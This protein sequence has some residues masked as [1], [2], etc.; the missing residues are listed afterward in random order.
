GEVAVPVPPASDF[1][2]VS[3]VTV[4]RP[5]TYSRGEKKIILIDCG[6][7]ESIVRNLLDRNITVQRVPY[8]YDFL[9]EKFDGVLISNGPGDP[10]VCV[11]TIVHVRKA[12][13]KG[14]PIL[15]IC[16]GHQILALAAGGDTYK[17]KFGHR[18]QNQP[19]RE[20]GT[21]KC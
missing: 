2:L 7:K 19:C 18:S 4:S 11:D 6:C 20:A 8:D 5:I 9:N 12:M 14:Y 17:L 3:E 10:K 21:R 13:E 1:D 16:L 15:G